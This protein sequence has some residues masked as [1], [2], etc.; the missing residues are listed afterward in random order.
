MPP[1]AASNCRF[2]PEL[3]L[4]YAGALIHS[5]VVSGMHSASFTALLTMSILASVLTSRFVNGVTKNCTGHRRC[6][7]TITLSGSLGFV[8]FCNKSIQRT[9]DS[10]NGSDCVR[11]ALL[12]D[13]T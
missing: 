5:H 8:V 6:G 11:L 3:A 13:L 2:H 7:L 9:A 10:C 12:R 1:L 4:L